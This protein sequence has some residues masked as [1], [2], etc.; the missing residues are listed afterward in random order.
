[1]KKSIAIFCILAICIL[2]CNQTE[3][4]YS[5][6]LNSDKL[7]SQFFTI[8]TSKDT[9][10]ITSNGAIIK[11]PKGAISGEAETVQLE[12]KEAYSIED[13]FRAGL[14]TQSNGQPLSSGGMIYINAVE[15]S[16]VTLKQKI[17]IAIPSVKLNDKMKIFKGEKIKGDQI[18]WTNPVDLPDNPQLN[19]LNKGKEIFLNNCASCH[20]IGKVVTGPDL[21]HMVKRNEAIIEREKAS[22][23]RDSE[24]MHDFLYAFTRNWASVYESSSYYRA[25]TCFSPST[26]T[27]FEQLSDTDLDNIYGYIENESELRN[28]PIPNNSI[29]DCLDS[30]RRYERTRDSLNGIRTQLEEKS[31]PMVIEKWNFDTSFRNTDTGIRVPVVIEDL[32]LVEP[33]SHKSL[34]YQFTVESFGWTNVDLYFK[35]DPRCVQSELIVS[36]REPYNERIN[37]YLVIPSIT[38]LLPGGPLTGKENSYGF[39]E[40]DGSIPLPPDSKAYIIA[41]GEYEDKIV[42]SQIDFI[43]SRKQSFQLELSLISKEEFNTKMSALNFKDLSISVADTEIAEPLRT[44][45]KDL[46]EAEKLKPKGCGCDCGRA[47]PAAAD[48]PANK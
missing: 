13:I 46:K 27:F 15:G 2:G 1:M 24:G 34:Y 39:F 35:D 3:K 23:V 40:K 33:L 5:Q 17:S 44:V 19:A 4:F 11:I 31:V 42:F 25:I 10:L 47:A 6:L 48:Y 41:V 29:F 30:C 45:V 7:P 12:I 20:A 38:A 14:T 8:N 22:R 43:T 32:D 16:T 18:N 21:A 26:M 36:T 9:V 37:L 28:L